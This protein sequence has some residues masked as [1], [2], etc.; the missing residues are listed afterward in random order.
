MTC[1]ALA[2][3]SPCLRSR[4]LG[5]GGVRKADP[6][7]KGSAKRLERTFVDPHEMLALDPIDMAA[8]QLNRLLRTF[9]YV[10]DIPN[11]KAGQDDKYQPQRLLRGWLDRYPYFTRLDLFADRGRTPERTSVP[12]DLDK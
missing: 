11:A 2:T 5:T 4:P 3:R 8:S 1:E 7:P 9:L 10:Q 6:L 12:G